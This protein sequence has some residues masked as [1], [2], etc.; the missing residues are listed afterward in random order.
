MR[1]R[2]RAH[3]LF[4]GL[5]TRPFNTSYMDG[6]DELRGHIMFKYS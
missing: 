2:A 6:N 3:V 4:G 1:R 5:A